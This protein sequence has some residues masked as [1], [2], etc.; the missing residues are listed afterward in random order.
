MMPPLIRRYLLPRIEEALQDTPVV[1]VN[2]PRQAGKTTLV[3]QLA[4]AARTYVTLDDAATLAGVRHD[5]VGFVRDLDMAVID[6]VQRA[7]ELL[8]SIKQ[9]VDQDRRPG[10]F[11][12][13]GSANVMTLPRV[14]D[15]LAGRIETH[16]LLPLAGCEIAGRPGQWLDAVFSG[17][18]PRSPGE[19]APAEVGPALVQRVLRGGYPQ[20]LART[21]TRRREAW[22]TQ[23]VDTLIQ[24]DVLDIAAVE[25]LDQLPRLLT[26]LAHMSG[27]LCN[28]A[29]LAGQIGL[30]NKTAEKYLGIFEQMFLL[31]RV[32]QWSGN[33]LS[34]MVKSPKVQF[35]DSGL[36]SG[37]LGVNEDFLL[38]QRQQLGAL[39]ESHVYGELLKQAAW[40]QQDYQV[41]T[42]RT[43]TQ[44]EVDFVLENRR[45]D[46]V[47]VEV[48]AAAS[49]QAADFSGLK[50]L[51]TLAG[52]RFLGGV[53]L[54]DGTQ[55]LP[56]GEVAGKPLWAVPLST[57]WLT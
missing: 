22:L 19:L 6:E 42:F 11:L 17:D 12:L 3:R 43:T 37:L 7:P 24:R 50:K 1:L 14:A 16:T 9:S 26:A 29:Q 2:G 46:I 36:L 18:M 30:D 23:Y 32:R 45:G 57:L 41:L 4:D 27:Q 38:R 55:T 39:L 40:A 13:T 56:M 34:R 5:P 15:S 49:F 53:L 21:T 35:I 33:G 47:G 28:F 25:K 31:R 54:Y 20:A 48:K 52:E 8:L 51:A 44:A 10:R